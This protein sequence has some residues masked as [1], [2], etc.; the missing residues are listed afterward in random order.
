MLF[1]TAIFSKSKAL[2]ARILLILGQAGVVAAEIK[3]GAEV[4]AAFGSENLDLLLVDLE[5]LPPGVKTAIIET[6]ALAQRPELIVLTSEEDPGVRASLQAAGCFAVVSMNLTDRELSEAL[7]AFIERHRRTA[8]DQVQVEQGSKRSVLADFAAESPAMQQLLRLASKVAPTD[9]SLLI[10]GETGVG[11]EW[12]ARAIHTEGPRAEAPFVAVNCA[13]IPETLLESELFGHEQGA[14]TGANRARRGLFELAHTGTL[15]LDEIGDLAP[16]L[17]AK[18]LRALQERTITR[19]GSERAVSVDVRIMAATNQD[20]GQGI[21]QKSFREDLYYRLSVMVLS[22]PPLRDRVEDIIP[23]ALSYFERFVGQ[24]NRFDIEGISPQAHSALEAHDWPGNVRELINAVERAVLLSDGG[25]LTLADL[26]E[27]IASSV[28]AG[29]PK[30]TDPPP[31]LEGK[32]ESWIG[33]PLAEVRNQIVDQ[34]E[35]EYLRQV[36][37]YTNG[38]INETAQIAGINS[39]TLYNKMRYHGLRKEQFRRPPRDA[40]A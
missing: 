29:L 28:V 20:L 4:W 16:H 10:L 35:A 26:P 3:D 32:L 37:S 19:L 38:R 33:L 7:L 25:M 8:V 14:Y 24:L 12:L 11:K 34:V 31:L 39:R 15:F 36:L 27:S 13:A 40:R 9:T 17:Q 18:L 2:R 6:R 5:S 22:V 23:L 21:A 30:E 1:H